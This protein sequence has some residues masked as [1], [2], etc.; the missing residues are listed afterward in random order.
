MSDGKIIDIFPSFM[1]LKLLLIFHEIYGLDRFEVRN[2]MQPIKT[3]RLPMT[4]MPRWTESNFPISDAGCIGE[5][6]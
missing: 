6:L 2:S 3:G 1:I 4:K 5:A